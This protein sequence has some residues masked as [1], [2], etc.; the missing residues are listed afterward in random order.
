[1]L[2]AAGVAEPRRAIGLVAAGTW[3]TKTWP[4]ASAARLARGL[5]EAG[6]DVLVL[7]GPAETRVLATLSLLA[8]GVR[9]LPP[10]DVAELAA[11]IERLGAVVGTD[12]GPRHLAVA[13]GVPSYAWFGPTHPDTWSPPQGPHAYWRTDLPCR[14]CDRTACP[15][16]SCMPSLDPGTALANVLEH[17]EGHVRNASDLRPAAGA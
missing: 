16:W 11:V 3:P 17:L 7:T 5:M 1:L 12:S 13:L 6:W 10:C 9:A 14:A 15:H 8:P 4:L 2:A